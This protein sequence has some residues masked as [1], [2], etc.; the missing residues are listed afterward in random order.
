MSQNTHNKQRP[1]AC[2]AGDPIAHSLSPLLHQT[3]LKA[4]GIEAQYKHFHVSAADFEKEI[5][6]LFKNEDFVGMNVTLPHKKA[7]LEIATMASAEARAAGVANL[8]VRKNGQIYA[9]NTDI[10]GFVA[11]LFAQRPDGF[12]RDKQIVV[13]GAG[14]A[15]QAAIIGA[16]KLNPQQ[17]MLSNRTD[18]KAINLAN[19]YENKVLALAWQDRHDA[20][21]H[22]DLLINTSA[23]G[24][25]G[26]PPLALSLEGLNKEALV[27]DLIYTPLQT[28]LLTEAKARG[29]DILNGLDM[30]I[31]QARPSFEAFYDHKAPTGIGIKRVLEQ[32]LEKRA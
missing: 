2:V 32:A 21:P 3:W 28:P 18:E 30:L 29:H 24:M 10:E 11:P 23:A 16:L 5:L 4:L 1:F 13:I 12:W 22:A 15:A 17:I 6:A 8:L 31:A 19:A 7:A 26:K 14:G 9:H 25:A 27:Y 20:L